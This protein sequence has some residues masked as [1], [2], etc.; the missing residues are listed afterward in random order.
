M[1]STNSQDPQ[2]RNV[3]NNMEE[4]P[5]QD[6]RTPVRILDELDPCEMGLTSTPDRRQLVSVDEEAED[7]GYDSDGNL[8]PFFNQVEGEDD[9]DTYQEVDLASRISSEGSDAAG[10]PSVEPSDDLTYCTLSVDE[11]MKLKVAEMKNI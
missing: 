3:P 7:L 2:V 9:M 11:I 6:S 1:Y 8:G 5:V 4:V 10:E